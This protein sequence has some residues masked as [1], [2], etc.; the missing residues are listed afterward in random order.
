[1]HTGAGVVI[2]VAGVALLVITALVLRPRIPRP[3]TDCLA[4][5]GGAAVGLGG[6]L[7]LDGD[8]SAASW[9]VAPLVL[10]LL[11]TVHIRALFSGSGPFRT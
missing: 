7:L 4:A 5:G 9:V 1:M 6:L 11:S 3:M 2:I 8:V 10:A